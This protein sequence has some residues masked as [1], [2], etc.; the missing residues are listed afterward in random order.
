MCNFCDWRGLVETID[1]MLLNEAYQF[2]ED[3]LNGIEDWV[4]ERSHCTEKQ[5]EA[6]ENIKRS[7]TRE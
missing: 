6:V 4:G 1:E 3:T 7:K 5:K 2:A